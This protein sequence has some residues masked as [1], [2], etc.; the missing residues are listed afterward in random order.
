MS[1]TYW[2]RP[3]NEP[4]I[5]VSYKA[6]PIPMNF[7]F[8]FQSSFPCSLTKWR[9]VQNI[10]SEGLLVGVDDFCPAIVFC[11]C[12]DG[13]FGGWIVWFFVYAL[14]L[15]GGKLFGMEA[16]EFLVQKILARLLGDMGAE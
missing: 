15:T 9:I 4:P 8:N 5:D 6:I 11:L 3:Y 14:N 16:H 10:A 12:A 2:N 7:D 13:V 1:K